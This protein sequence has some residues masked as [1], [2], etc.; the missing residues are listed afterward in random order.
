M[1]SPAAAIAWQFRH[2]HRFGLWALALYFGVLVLI[3]VFVERAGDEVTLEEWRFSVVVV[4]PVSSAI[5]LF[6]AVFSFGLE[7]DL[8][9]RQSIF[10]ARMFTLPLSHTALAGWP[11]LCGAVSMAVLWW[12]TRLLAVWPSG[13]WVPWLW[14]GLFGA[15]ILAW[16]QALMWL[17]YPLPGLRVAIT[18]AWL[19]LI[20]FAALLA[21]YTKASETLMIGLLAPQLPLAYLVACWA[22]ARARRGDI[23]SWAGILWRFSVEST[24]SCGPRSVDADPSRPLASW[25]PARAQ[26]WL[27]WQ[28]HGRVLPVWVAIALPFELSLLF[29]FTDSRTLLA[30]TLLLALLT[31]PF[32]ASFVAANLRKSS[33][34]SSDSYELTPFIA[35]R[36][37]PSASIVG[38]KLL[39]AI[40][41]TLVTWSLVL[42]AVP[43]ALSLSGS[44]WV[45]VD[46]AQ[47]LVDIAGAPRAV[48]LGLLVLAALAVTTWKQLVQSLYLGMS[49]RAWLVKANGFLTLAGLT[50]V[51]A[52]GPWLVEGAFVAR[53]WDALPWIFGILVAL[54]LVAVLW[55]VPR[56]A[57]SR[58]L[59]D[60]ALIVSASC[61]SVAVLSL[62]GLFV[63]LLPTMLF[64]RHVL[65]FAA[66]LLVPWVRLAAA[67]LALAWNRHR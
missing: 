49:G 40:H 67:P 14:P 36:P 62:Y 2:R 45:I 52:L 8:A 46:P 12:A 6:L 60:R 54:K 22:V 35:T 31:P 28:R 19:S 53:L 3:R 33:A 32:I 61:W 37:L 13:V 18:V 5:M 48:V 34:E 10:P 15:V 24:S 16:T 43:L 29:V 39:A 63:W 57:A 42:V 9:A 47:D 23:P 38:A 25:T 11:M 20:A 17:S 64:H 55:T 21:F 51:V 59:S 44:W 4:V 66:I 50:V 1:R 27:E 58:L 56:L 7:G 41:S 30:E 65:A 26:L